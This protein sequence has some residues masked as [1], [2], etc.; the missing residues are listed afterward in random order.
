MAG[1]SHQVGPIYHRSLADR[2]TERD[3]DEVRLA[4]TTGRRAPSVVTGFHDDRHC[5]NIFAHFTSHH[6]IAATEGGM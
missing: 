6:V 4:L 1:E 2:I 5:P 3:H